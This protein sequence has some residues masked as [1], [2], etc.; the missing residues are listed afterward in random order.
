MSKRLQEIKF[1]AGKFR[2]ENS[3]SEKEPV[4]IKSILQKNNILTVYKP[5]SS[6]V[7]GMSIKIM[8]PTTSDK[9]VNRFILVNS[10]HSVGKQHFTVCHELYHLYYQEK[11]SVSVSNAGAFDK[12]GD[13]EEY[14]ADMFAAYLLLPEWGLWEMIPDEEKN[15]NKISIPTIFAIEQYYSCSHSALLHRLQGL[16]LIDDTFKQ[17]QLQGVK[18]NARRLGYDMRLY[19]AGNHNLVI[20]DYGSMAYQAWEK[21]IISESAYYT[22]LEDYGVDV[23]KLPNPDEN[24]ED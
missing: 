14:N 8:S 6:G 3:L 7:S 15:K 21:G 9:D 2:Q 12:K 18:T 24:G 11:F 19:E 1:L 4:R 16:K 23:S 13:P 22:L 20:G 10:N 17:K 5:L